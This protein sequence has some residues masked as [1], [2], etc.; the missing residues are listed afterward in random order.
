MITTNFDEYFDFN[1]TEDDLYAYITI[2]EGTEEVRLA[3]IQKALLK[4]NI[5]VGIQ[6]ENIR[7]F[8][9]FNL[10]G[11]EVLIAKGEEPGESIPSKLEYLISDDNSTPLNSKVNFSPS[12]NPSF[13][14]VEGSSP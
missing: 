4:E 2:N 6:L 10:Y 5:I 14:C 8:L 12:L 9:K 11:E 1:V 13:C 7:N 3:D